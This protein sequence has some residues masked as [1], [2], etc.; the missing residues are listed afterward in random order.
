MKKIYRVLGNHGRT[1]IPFALRVSLSLNRNDILSF[2]QS[3]DEIIIRKE[4]ICD[5]CSDADERES[6]VRL[7]A[8]LDGLSPEQQFNALTHLS[9]KWAE[10][11]E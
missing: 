10:M 11:Q 2:R 3:G 8:L 7:F 9:L 6:N 1:T 4:K 5:S